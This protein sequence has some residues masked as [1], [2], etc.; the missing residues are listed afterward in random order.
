MSS[1]SI[2]Y[3]NSAL[4]IILL[5]FGLLKKRGKLGILLTAMYAAI[6]LGCAF[7]Y[8]QGEYT[9]RNLL[10]WPFLY[11]FI[12]YV[13]LVKPFRTDVGLYERIYFPN[14]KILNTVF[15][16]YLLF[17][18]LYIYV[19]SGNVLEAL[20]SGSWLAIYVNMR[21]EDAVFHSNLFEQVLINVTT[22]FRIPAVL[23]AFYV[24]AKKIDY[25]WKNLLLIIPFV[26]S[27]IWAVFTASRTEFVVIGF[28]Y[29][30][31]F[32]ILS[33]GFSNSFKRIVLIG[34]SVFGAVA[35]IFII[36]VSA[37]RFGE[38]ETSW[39]KDYFGDSFIVAHNTIGYTDRLGNGSYFFKQ[40]FQ[41]LGIHVAPYHCPIDDGTSFHSLIGMRYSDFGIIGTVVYALVGCIWMSYLTNKKRIL[42]GDIYLL[43]YYF[44][45]LFIGALYDSATAFSWLI[46]LFVAYLLS[47]ISK[48][49]VKA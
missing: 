8:S 42:I 23:Y 4:Y 35:A 39:L 17:S 38:G 6:A 31:C 45:V 48:K 1:L 49:N 33:K 16:I 22:Y 19:F 27:A 44:I 26:N 46:V 3:I 10:L 12:I 30:A 11:Y 14:T 36:A 9:V 25:K 28:I 21:G 29:I 40:I 7:F 13:I 18:F 2:L 20:R 37:S 47:Y 15:S 34:L 32:L 5:C 41:I 24:Y 43:L